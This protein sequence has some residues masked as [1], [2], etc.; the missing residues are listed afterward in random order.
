MQLTP[1]LPPFK[2]T[3]GTLLAVA[4]IAG[5]GYTLVTVVPY[6]TVD[7][8][9]NDLPIKMLEQH[10]GH[11]LYVYRWCDESRL[12]IEV[13]PGLT[14]LALVAYETYGPR[15]FDDVPLGLAFEQSRSIHPQVVGQ[16][17]DS[18]VI[19]GE[20]Y[21]LVVAV[22]YIQAEVRVAG[23]TIKTV[24][25]RRFNDYFYRWTRQNSDYDL[26]GMVHSRT[27]IHLAANGW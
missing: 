4:D 10:P 25:I 15:V 12:D 11:D 7:V 18:D 26:G 1:H 22:P 27:V 5:K 19:K 3:A 14:A 2:Q 20:E 24:G 16:V 6:K 23:K 17:L 9:V 21:S 13:V 8:C